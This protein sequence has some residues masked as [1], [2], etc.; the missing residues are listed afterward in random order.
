[1]TVVDPSIYIQSIKD[2][3]LKK[4]Q[5]YPMGVASTKKFDV[6]QTQDCRGMKVKLFTKVNLKVR[7]N[8]IKFESLVYS[9]LQKHHL[10]IHPDLFKQNDM[11]CIEDIIG[12]HP[13]SVQREDFK[14][15]ITANIRGWTAPANTIT[16][17]WAKENN[18]ATTA[19]SARVPYFKLLMG[20]RKYRNRAEKVEATTFKVVCKEKDGLHFKTLMSEAW[21]PKNKPCGVFMPA[22]TDLV[23]SPETYKQLLQNHNTYIQLTTSVIIEGLHPTILE[24]EIMVDKETVSA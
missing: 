12:A 3:I 21:K 6:Q 18:G 7:L 15:E 8:N 17:N 14:A 22:C 1:M 24:Q 10:F 23:T 5:E 4:L 9:Y 20:E 11:V 16:E 13:K 2:H 19:T